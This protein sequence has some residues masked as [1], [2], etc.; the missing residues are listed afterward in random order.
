MQITARTAAVIVVASLLSAAPLL[1]QP[2]LTMDWEAMAEQLVTQ[3]AP[4]PGEKIVL[5]ARPDSS[6]R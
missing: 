3:L 2:R 5:V 1:A 4:E 6:T